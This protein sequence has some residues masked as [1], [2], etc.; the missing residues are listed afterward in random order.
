MPE[1]GGAPRG[2][3]RRD[4]EVIAALSRSGGALRIAELARALGVSDETV[5]R[6]ARRLEAEGLVLKRHGAAHL[7]DPPAEPSF[8][9]RMAENPEAKRRIAARVTA[10]IADGDS[11][12]LDVGSTTAYIAEALRARS[13]LL[14]VTNSVAVAW[15]LAARA[16]NRVFMAGGELRAHDGAA[17]GAE[18]VAFAR[19]FRVRWA[20]LSAA[21]ID[22][23]AGF[24]LHDLQEAE[25]SR[26]ILDQARTRIVAAD[27]SKFGRPAPIVVGGLDMADALV[28]DGAP[29]PPLATAL[30]AGGVEIVLA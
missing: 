14:V 21:G 13:G 20:V 11:L 15:T 26:A 3:S 25:F 9:R 23:E 17:F 27:R 12:F 29:P 5:R 16:G 22:A 8:A 6:A 2:G 10:M 4:R 18:A 19:R 28:T 30:A 7:A 1:D 24:L